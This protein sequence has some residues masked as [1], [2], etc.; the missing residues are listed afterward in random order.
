VWASIDGGYSWGLCSENAEFSDRR[1]PYTALEEDG[2]LF[3]MGGRERDPIS[4]Q[5]RLTNDVWK[6]NFKFDDPESVAS[7]CHLLVPQ[8]KKIGLQCLPSDDNFAQGLWG[9]SCAQCPMLGG[10]DPSPSPTSAQVSPLV[11]AL[12]VFVIAFVATTGIV[13]YTF[14]KLRQAGIDV[15]KITTQQW[16]KHNDSG[17]LLDDRSTASE[18]I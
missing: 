15:S 10:A 5:S 1:Y 13:I 12:V 7:F 11:I 4:G 6:S 2:T 14:Y 3:V 9:A 18:S 8:C 17:T 16:N